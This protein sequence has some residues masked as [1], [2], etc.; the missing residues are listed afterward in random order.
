VDYQ[1]DITRLAKA[2]NIPV[3]VFFDVGANIGQTASAALA[4]F[5]DAR[6]FAFEPH[7]PAFGA[8]M[9]SVRSPYFSAFNLALSDKCGEAKFFEYGDLATC[10]SMVSNS[11]YA[12][13]AR[14][15]SKTV[16][17]EC[18]TL[19]NF[20]ETHGVEQIDVLKID[21]EGHDVAVLRGAERMLGEGRVRFV[22]VE[23]NT[24]LPKAETSGGALLPIC[25][26]LEPLGFSF[27]AS[28]PE[29]MITKDEL[30]VTSNAL[31]ARMA[32]AK[33]T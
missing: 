21:T 18:Q 32:S 31:F 13:R 2:F 29:Y 17:V 26:I 6:I 1:H 24:M 33:A 25:T 23:F 8:L 9:N 14:H 11:Q 12:V 27:V 3:N 20:C 5:P 4:N 19:D 28:Y 30:F 10:N 7:A 22:Y 15:P 16:I